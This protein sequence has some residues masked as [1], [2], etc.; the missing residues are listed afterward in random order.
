[1]RRW[2]S[3]KKNLPQTMTS[4]PAAA[5][6]PDKWNKQ[7]CLIRVFDELIYDT[8]PNLT[9]VRIGEDWTVWR[10]FQPRLPHEQGPAHP[11]KPAEMRFAFLNLNAMTIR[12]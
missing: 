9:N 3:V 8:D 10:R 2:G 1:M 11:E 12:C 7:M 5:T 6:G 4:A